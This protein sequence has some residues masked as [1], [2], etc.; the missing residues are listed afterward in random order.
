MQFRV[1]KLVE[2]RDWSVNSREGSTGGVGWKVISVGSGVKV[3]AVVS[4]GDPMVEKLGVG[5]EGGGSK[6]S[7]LDLAL[8][9][10]HIFWHD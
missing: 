7:Y 3:I 4:N 2:E 5:P 1:I 8:A 6:P 9:K 10:I